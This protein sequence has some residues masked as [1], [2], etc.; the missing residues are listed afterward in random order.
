MKKKLHC[1]VIK[2]IFLYCNFA[3]LKYSVW[4]LFQDC[5]IMEKAD[6]AVL[7]NILLVTVMCLL[8]FTELKKCVDCSIGLNL[9]PDKVHLYNRKRGQI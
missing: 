6:I 4:L 7:H 3:C 5:Q 9:Q 8:Q 2:K 1:N